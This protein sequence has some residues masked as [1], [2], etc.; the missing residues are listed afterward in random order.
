[1]KIDIFV[2]RIGTGKVVLSRGELISVVKGSPHDERARGTNRAIST[3]LS[4]HDSRSCDEGWRLCN[5]EAGQV[6]R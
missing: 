3:S 2:R 6:A 5:C 4:R 1:M